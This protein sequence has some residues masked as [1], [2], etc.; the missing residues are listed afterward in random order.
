MVKDEF[1]DKRKGW[2][3]ANHEI[4]WTNRFQ[5]SSD[6]IHNS[7]TSNH[8]R[9]WK[10]EVNNYSGQVSMYK[11][12]QVA[13]GVITAFGSGVNGG[14]R[15]A[16]GIFPVAKPLEKPKWILIPNSEGNLSKSQID[17]V[18]NG[19]RDASQYLK[20]VGASRASR[21][22]IIQS[23]QIESIKVSTAGESFYGLRFHDFGKNA[24]PLGQYL[25]ETFTPLTNRENLAL[26]LQWNLATGIK[27]WQI[28]PSAVYIRGRV[29]A[30]TEYGSRFIGGGDQIF[31]Y[32]PHVNGTL[33]E[34]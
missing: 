31:V 19:V 7:N 9:K 6:G 17:Q 14:N 5:L 33:V 26:P 3:F 4:W 24:R 27:Q 1:L 13:E 34:P 25:F 20:S 2:F 8:P 23:F 32:R 22:Q 28:R 16:P 30:Q 11:T 15:N 18:Y 12:Y 10:A 21:V 29:G